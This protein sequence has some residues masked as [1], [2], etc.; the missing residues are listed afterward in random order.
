MAALIAVPAAAQ[1]A[2]IAAEA[3]AGMCWAVTADEDQVA[4]AAGA[5]T[6]VYSHQG[7][8]Q[9]GCAVTPLLAV[10][11]LVRACQSSAAE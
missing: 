9:S 3:E 1:R 5:V 8:C 4:D 10:L 11:L 6:A 7:I 2:A